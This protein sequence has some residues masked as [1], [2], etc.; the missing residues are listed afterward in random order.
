M[1]T[2]PLNIC[3][4]EFQ[5]DYIWKNKVGLWYYNS[6]INEQNKVE[7]L[8]LPVVNLVTMKKLNLN[9]LNK[10]LVFNFF[11]TVHSSL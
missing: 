9:S 10:W 1:Q 6:E 3:A 5:K 2:E 4:Q 8:L 11:K 7:M